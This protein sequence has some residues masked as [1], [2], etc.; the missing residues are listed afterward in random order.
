MQ[1]LTPKDPKSIGD[2]TLIGRLGSGGMGIVYLAANGPDSVALKVIRES[3]LEDQTQATRFSREIETL[4]KINSPFV[5][6]IIN[7]GVTDGQAW[8]ATEFVN[9]PDLKSLVD[10]KGPLKEDAWMSLAEGLLQGIAA[11]HSQGIIHR[12]IKPANVIVAESG[13]KIIDFGIAQVSDATSVTSTGLVAGTPA[14]FSPEQIEG[15]NLTVATDLFS[16]GSVLTYAAIGKS[17]WGDENTMTK[18]SVYGILVSEPNLSGTSPEQLRV[19]S[20]LLEKEPSKRS[21]PAEILA[22][23]NGM[24]DEGAEVGRSGHSKSPKSPK[25]FVEPKPLETPI[26]EP[27]NFLGKRTAFALGGIGLVGTLAGA[28]LFTPSLVEETSPESTGSSS[29]DEAL[30]F[31]GTPLELT[32]GGLVPQTGVLAFLGP[33]VE[34]AMLLAQQDINESELGVT[35]DLIFAD[36]GDF[37]TQI[38]LDSAQFLAEAGASVIVGPL[39]SSRAL[40]VIDYLTLEQGIVMI[41][42]ANSSRIFETYDSD[43]LYFRT[44][45]SD[46]QQ[47]T[48]LADLMIADGATEIAIVGIDDA[49]AYELAGD[50]VRRFEAMADT[51]GLPPQ[52][53][54]IPIGGSLSEGQLSGLS[55]ADAIL[56]AT[57]DE[58]P[59]VVTQLKR[60]EQEMPDYIW[61]TET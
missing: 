46:S 8:Y 32:I 39:S 35:V 52:Y 21:Y 44:A 1:P 59:A 13:P 38:E 41:S 26:R 12:D 2:Y 5:A 51:S 16:A 40:N 23:Q 47:G 11:I 37:S 6:K 24:T 30:P 29:P 17:P 53:L 55:R 58:A 49:Y 20:P 48:A 45:A 18:A 57:F 14:W 33:S 4:K 56:L 22:Q 54:E 7:S 3:L 43:N 60:L 34:A 36:E 10:A 27:K 9:G 50:V 28:L 19:I 25:T 15:K 42:P 31:G 61:S